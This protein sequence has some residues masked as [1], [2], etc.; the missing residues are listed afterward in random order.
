MRL[1]CVA[2]FLCAFVSGIARFGVGCFCCFA[3]TP[4]PLY[5]A[6]RGPTLLRVTPPPLFKA[7]KAGF[8]WC[9]REALMAVN[10]KMKFGH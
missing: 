8:N 4:L 2:W 10:S 3:M 6:L 1:L 9:L 5:K 7:V